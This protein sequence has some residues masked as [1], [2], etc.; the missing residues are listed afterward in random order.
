MSNAGPDIGLNPD[1]GSVEKA[2]DVSK[3]SV[4]IPVYNSEATIGALVDTVVET[5]HSHFDSLEIILINDGSLDNSHSCALQAVERH[6]N[7]VKY[8]RLSR[9][10]GEHNAVM[11]GLN[12]SSGDC[13]AIIDDDFQNPPSEILALVEK[14]CQGYDVVYGYYEEKHHSWF[15][16]FGSTVNNRFAT[17]LLDKP[18]SLYLSSFKVISAQLVRT[19]I[20]YPGPY[21]Y[22]DSII[23]RSTKRIGQQLCRHEDRKA[24]RSNYTFRKLV[25]VWSN[26]ITNS[27]IEPLRIASLMGFLMSLLAIILIAFFVVSRLAG[28]IFF[29]QDIPTGWASLIVTIIFFGGLQLC[30]LGLIGEYL[31]RMFFTVN[32]MPQFVVSEEYGIEDNQGQV[33]ASKLR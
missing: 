4:L 17:R 26:M 25:H 24:G 5:L 1:G 19:I 8:I 18:S 10:F 27:S 13:V 16:N 22:I 11:C 29:K 9:N 28:G 6:P 20:K 7:M 31:G 3:L 32:R 15:R 12:Y 21:P 14:L 23:L 2:F 33:D 30:V